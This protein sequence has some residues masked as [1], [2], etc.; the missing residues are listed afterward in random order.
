MTLNYKKTFKKNDVE[1][2]YEIFLILTT[3]HLLKCAPANTHRATWL[4]NDLG[5]SPVT[6]KRFTKEKTFGTLNTAIS[7]MN[8]VGYAPFV[9]SMDG[10]LKFGFIKGRDNVLKSAHIEGMVNEFLNNYLRDNNTNYPA[11]ARNA[12]MN[13]T[14]YPFSSIGAGLKRKFG[15]LVKFGFPVTVE[16]DSVSITITIEPII[17]LE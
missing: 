12:G 10:N 17:N 11:I 16:S 14:R 13:E 15:R 3:I 5:M 1:E 9:W 6:I 2:A 8:A 4:R 7:Y